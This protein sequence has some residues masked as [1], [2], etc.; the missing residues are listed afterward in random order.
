LSNATTD[1]AAELTRV[2]D[3]ID[4]LRTAFVAVADH[5]FDANTYRKAV[6]VTF[7]H[8]I[9][10]RLGWIISAVG[11]VVTLGGGYLAGQ[12]IEDNVTKQLKRQLK[13]VD[14]LLLRDRLAFLLDAAR[15][16]A[17]REELLAELRDPSYQAALKSLVSPQ[18]NR[19][20]RALALE[21]ASHASE[22]SLLFAAIGTLQDPTVGRS[23]KI[24]IAEALTRNPTEPVVADLAKFAVGQL[25]RDR[26]LADHITRLL[27]RTES[28]TG[29]THQ[30][31][32]RSAA[33]GDPAMIQAALTFF[34]LNTVESDEVSHFV[35]GALA[36]DRFKTWRPIYEISTTASEGLTQDQEA[37][38]LDFVLPV[39]TA[40]G[41]ITDQVRTEIV[42]MIEG[43][44]LRN[45]GVLSR[46]NAEALHRYF[47]RKFAAGGRP[48]LLREHFIADR[49][50]S[51]EVWKRDLASLF[52][53]E[54]DQDS[55]AQQLVDGGARLEWS[56]E[57]K[58]YVVLD[59]Q[60]IQQRAI[61]A[62]A[63]GSLDEFNSLMQGSYFDAALWRERVTPFFPE[64]TGGPSATG[65]RAE[66]DALW[67]WTETSDLQWDAK[68]RTYITAEQRSLRDLERGDLEAFRDFM[69]S[70][71]Y[72]QAVWLAQIRPRFPEFRRLE[73]L[74]GGENDQDELAYWVSMEAP[75]WDSDRKEFRTAGS[76]T[77][78]AG[79]ERAA[80]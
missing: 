62:L 20:Q 13:G 28:A 39:L 72:D 74:E 53:G 46:D 44:R 24:E 55:V 64:W 34:V 26:L 30:L 63:E 37:T 47:A 54:L 7:V 45:D 8:D 78:R 19:R 40:S 27:A 57:E 21:Y 2:R 80:P 49:R 33:G 22:D 56:L 60:R 16:G 70:S 3:E 68:S 31:V 52:P 58:R 51:A 61:Q 6:L 23:L 32:L 38:V 67:N 14:D 12:Y 4:E 1:L 43:R 79:G 76:R 75:V 5:R 36:Q 66:Q 17:W 50:F 69:R 35:E 71:Y 73:V 29:A 11:V 41:D 65:A 42:Q 15:E 10:T 25:D 18:A 48:Q 77:S 59:D 9:W